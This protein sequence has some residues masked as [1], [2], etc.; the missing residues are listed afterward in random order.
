MGLYKADKRDKLNVHFTL[1]TG[2]QKLDSRA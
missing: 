1:M 2:H